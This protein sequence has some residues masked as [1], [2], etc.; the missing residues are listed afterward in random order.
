MEVIRTGGVAIKCCVKSVLYIMFCLCGIA[1]SVKNCFLSSHSSYVLWNGCPCGKSILESEVTVNENV[2]ELKKATLYLDVLTYGFR[3]TSSIAHKAILRRLIA[4]G[5]DKPRWRN[6]IGDRYKDSSPEMAKR[7]MIFT[8]DWWLQ[9]HQVLAVNEWLLFDMVLMLFSSF[10][11]FLDWIG[12]QSMY[13]PH[14]TTWAS[15]QVGRGYDEKPIFA[16]ETIT[17]SGSVEGVF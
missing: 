2:F 1:S 13:F 10:K 9:G 6:Q 7:F 17:C 12:V 4:D 8:M 16:S 5:C 11:E 3:V 14:A 15:Y